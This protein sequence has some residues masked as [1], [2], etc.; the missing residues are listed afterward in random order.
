MD[1]SCIVILLTI[2]L[3]THPTSFSVFWNVPTE[4][5]SK[6]NINLSLEEYG[7]K[8][9][10]NYT[11][12]GENIVIFYQFEFGLYPYFKDYNK[13]APVNGGMPQDCNLGA[14]LKKVRK[15]ITNII[16]DENFTNH[17]IIDFEHW[18]PL[19][20]ELYDTKKVYQEASIERVKRNDPSLSDAE[21]RQRAVI[22][23]DNAAKT[24]LV[25]TIKTARRMRPKAFWS[26]YG[27]PY[28]NYNAGQKD[29]DYNCSRKF[30]SYNDK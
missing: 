13:S 11:F 7:I 14:H 26:F 12:Y 24:F 2:F 28:C 3:T 25:E 6:M 19:F 30:E 17:A 8:A 4:I 5:C 22:E 1:F 21:A 23:F 29:S 9:N 10:P 27:F 16:P 15:D 18:R 20:E